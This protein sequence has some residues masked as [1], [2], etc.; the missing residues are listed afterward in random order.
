[1]EREVQ[2]T[3]NELITRQDI[4]GREREIQRVAKVELDQKELRKYLDQ[5]IEEIKRNRSK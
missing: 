3:V 1:M 4:L 5:V 2:K